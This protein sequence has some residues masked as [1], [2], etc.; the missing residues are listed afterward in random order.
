MQHPLPGRRQAQPS[1]VIE[2]LS[3][4]YTAV[5]RQ[6]WV[7]MLPILLDV[8]LWLGP[9]VSYSPLVGPVV[10]QAA[11]WTRQVALGP[12]RGPANPDLV[13]SLDDS[14]QWLIARTDET[15]GLDALAWGPIALPSPATL[16]SASDELAFVSGWFE[17][18]ALFG[19]SLALGLLL[20][21]WF[22]AGLANASAGSR[23]G[24]LAAGRGT[25]RAV[26]DVLGLTG[27]LL[28]TAFLLGVPVV[29]LIGFTALLS[30]PVAA[31]GGA[32]VAGGVLFAAVHLFFAVDA[33]F[34]SNAG[35][36]TAIQRSVG[37]VRRH[38]RA[39]VAL[40][41]LTW[42]IL[43]G[44]AQVWDALGNTLQSPVGVALAIL[45]NAYIASGLIA[46]GMIFYTQR[47]EPG[48][49]MKTA[50]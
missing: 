49:A 4:G 23:D 10:T 45:G 40:I 14:R 26:I 39:S 21:G 25:P 44:M 29:L 28:G 7:L 35:P 16:P 12:R 9:H 47:T 41:L 3:A 1:G 34:I 8:F 2:T 43:A 36:L 38:L 27:V 46:A 20:G 17:G 42:L 33:I 18:V 37:V 5:N 11:E 19:A 6:L 24:P 48:L 30:P 22:Y 31:L 32:L 50:G 15:N 13:G